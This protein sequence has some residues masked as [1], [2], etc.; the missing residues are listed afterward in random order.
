MKT[1]ALFGVLLVLAVCQFK[2]P[3]VQA[4]TISA[5]GE[6]KITARVAPTHYVIVD[7]SDQII[8]LTFADIDWRYAERLDQS[9]RRCGRHF[10]L[11][12]KIELDAVAS[13]SRSD[14]T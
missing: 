8:E 1:F 12:G 9:R 2:P 10:R 14:G 7:D 3:L 11:Q 5:S 13:S 6:I 4:G